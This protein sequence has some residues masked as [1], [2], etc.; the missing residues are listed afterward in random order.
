MRGWVA[1]V[2]VGVLL[3]AVSVLGWV[4]LLKASDPSW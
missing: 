2:A 4:I 3:M 1:V